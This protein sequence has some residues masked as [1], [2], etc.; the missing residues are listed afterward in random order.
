VAA[1]AEDPAYAQ[2]MTRG[3]GDLGDPEVFA[4]YIEQLLR[5]AQP[6]RPRFEGW[7]PCTTF[8]WVDGAEF[9]ARVAVRHELEGDLW[10]VGGHIG[11]WVRPSARRRGHGLAAFRAVLPE[12]A[13]L[14]IDPALVTCDWDNEPSRRIIEAA[15]GVLENQIGVKLRFWVP[16]HTSSLARSRS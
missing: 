9:L 2:R 12:A 13:A 10:T 4:V 7:V 6:G 3:A 11:Y 15:G 5:E 14:N 1:L 8:W 16:T